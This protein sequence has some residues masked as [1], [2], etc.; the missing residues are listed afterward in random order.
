MWVGGGVPI[1]TSG[2]AGG[3]VGT[4][5]TAS[6]ILRYLSSANRFEQMVRGLI[7]TRDLAYFAF[8]IGTFLLLAKASVE[9]VRWR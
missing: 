4:N 7:D 2:A 9:S 3:A 1:G 6:Q 5:S 8:M